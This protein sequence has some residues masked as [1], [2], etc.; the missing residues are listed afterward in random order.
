M[1]RKYLISTIIIL[2][3]LFITSCT[4]QSSS[5]CEHNY[6]EVEKLSTCNEG[7]YTTYKC[8]LC[9]SEYSKYFLKNGHNYKL[10]NDTATCTNDGIKTYKCEN[11]NDEYNENSLKTNH[12]Y[13]NGKCAI[14]NELEVLQYII[15]QDRPLISWQLSRLIR[16]KVGEMK[17]CTLIDNGV[18]HEVVI[19]RLHFKEAY[20]S[21]YNYEEAYHSHI[22]QEDMENKYGVYDESTL[23]VDF[24][25]SS[26]LKL[27]IDK[28][29]LDFFTKYDEFLV[30]YN[31]LSVNLIG[32]DFES[33]KVYNV[34]DWTL[35]P[36]EIILPLNEGKICYN[37]T[38]AKEIS[39]ML[40]E[41]QYSDMMDF[42]NYIEG[43]YR[44]FDGA[45]YDMIRVWY[46]AIMRMVDEASQS[47]E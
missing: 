43:E 46:N 19:I 31:L 41:P 15:T 29:K 1:K 5:E 28:S 40:I 11:C 10:I 34:I 45:S 9:D 27:M 8:K 33:D 30:S 23:N 6:Y 16:V 18:S 12:I 24:S 32:E 38:I 42:N 4:M 20:Y 47:N 3:C 35:V 26:V 2:F 36:D 21:N 25:D 22:S 13:E 14:C 39:D 44:L 7:G 37:A 17:E